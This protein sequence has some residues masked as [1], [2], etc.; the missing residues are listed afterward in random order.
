MGIGTT[1]THP[2]ILYTNNAERLRIDTSGNVGIGTSSPIH[3]LSIGNPASSV[4]TATPDIVGLG[5]TFSST[6]G[7]NAKLRIWQDTSVSQYMGFGVSSNQF[8]YIATGTYA[9]VWYSNGTERMRID[10]SGNVGIGTSSPTASK[11]HIAGYNGGT[12]Y[13]IR[14]TS[15]NSGVEWA[16][17]TGGSAASSSFLAFRDIG[18]SAERMRIDTSGS[19]LIGQTTAATSSRGVTVN[20]NQQGFIVRNG[21]ND[22][23]EI[24]VWSGASD[25]VKTQLQAGSGGIGIVGTRSNHPI[26]FTT[27]DNEKMRID[28]SG[29]TFIGGTTGFG[30]LVVNA[31]GS[32]IYLG[33]N[34][35]TK[36]FA[37]ADNGQIYA[38][39]T[40]I[41]SLSDRRVKE[42]IKP[43]QYG[44]DAVTKLNPVTFNFIAYPELQPTY[45]FIAQEVEPILPELVDDEKNNKAEDGTP[46]KTLKMGDMLPIL[47]KAIQE[48]KATVDAQAARIAALESN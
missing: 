46:Y 24:G 43:I 41:T 27:N 10:S 18:N 45:G 31:S 23:T 6:A 47:V 19:V 17:E 13:P 22:Y 33:Y 4:S 32:D 28:T 42:N 5:G 11:L 35:A 25:G 48:L 37:V 8:D 20:A 16:F 15:S 1:T 29:N 3:K 12:T 36:Q 2:V 40:S 44:L 21:Q 38:Q 39:F 30:R 9:H 26:V 14:M 7:A 34:G